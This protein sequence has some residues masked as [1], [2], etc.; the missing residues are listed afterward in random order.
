MGA[1]GTVLELKCYQNTKDNILINVRKIKH[2]DLV[3]LID[4]IDKGFQWL[5]YMYKCHPCKQVGLSG[6]SR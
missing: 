1:F 2:R 5:L 6:C 4:H 3:G